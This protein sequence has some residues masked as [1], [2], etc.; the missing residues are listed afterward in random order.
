VYSDPSDGNM[1]KWNKETRLKMNELILAG[2]TVRRMKGGYIAWKEP[3]G[4]YWK[5]KGMARAVDAA[6]GVLINQ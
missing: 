5:E 4:W 2:W 6:Y 3:N 1:A